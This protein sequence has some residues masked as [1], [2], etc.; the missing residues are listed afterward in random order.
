VRDNAGFTRERLVRFLEAGG[1]Q[2][3]MLFAGNMVKQPCFDEM[4]KV[5]TGFRVCGNLT[6]TDKVMN[7]T[8]W[9]GVY[10]GLTD[11]MIRYMIGSI[12]TF[13]ETS[14]AGA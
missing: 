6:V 13:V 11:E 10:P 8:F 1:I 2:T 9:I 3:R 5:G 14:A 4:R 12:K 7:D